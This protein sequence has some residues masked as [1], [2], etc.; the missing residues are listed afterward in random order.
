V[1]SVDDEILELLDKGHSRAD[2]L[3]ALDIMRSAGVD[4]APTF[5]AFTPWTTLERYRTLL[6]DIAVLGLIDA[7]APVQLSIRLLI[8]AG[9]HIL[10]IDGIDAFVGAFDPQLLGHAW[11][12]PDPRMDALQ[13][14]VQTRVMQDEAAGRPRHEIFQA[15]WQ[16]AWQL[17]GSTAPSLTTP[18]TEHPIAR[19]SENWYCCAEPTCEQLA[20]F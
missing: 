17:D 6:H 10:Q 5:V 20:S 16:L 9:S 8:P 12:H 2:L 4:L 19:L 11:Q 3:R 18:G 1:E 7:V 15:V 14:Q 13:Q